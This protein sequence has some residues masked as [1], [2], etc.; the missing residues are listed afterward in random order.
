MSQM[1]RRGTRNGAYLNLPETEL[2]RVLVAGTDRTT[3]ETHLG[4]RLYQRLRDLAIA[5]RKH[6]RS[7]GPC[8]YLLHG[9]MGS[10]LGTRRGALWVNP[11]ALAAGR[12]TELALPGGRGVQ[13]LGLQTFMYLRLRLTLELT[14]F[15][16]RV[17][18]YDWRRDI[19]ALGRELLERVRSESK[20]PVAVVAHSMGGLVARAAMH[21]EQEHKIARLIMLG[22]PSYGSF[23]AV[24]A[25]RGAYPP[26]H[27]I[28]LLDHEHDPDAHAQKV[29]ATFPGLYQLLPEP[30]RL[31]G[32]DLRR[33]TAWPAHGPRLS[34]TLL[35]ESAA[36]RA[37]LAP[38]D[39]RMTLI[40]G[41]Q[42]HTVS[43]MR[44]V[45]GEFLF[46]VTRNGDGTVPLSLA[47][48]RGA[49]TYYVAEGHTELPSN[50]QVIAALVDVLKAGKTSR[51]PRQWRQ[52]RA[53]ARVLRESDLRS[54][55]TISH[56]W[57]ALDAA[58]QRE[59][60][61]GIVFPGRAADD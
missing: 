8:V 46:E 43:A 51:L 6:R 36:Y 24:L 5:A 50:G 44:R 54:T 2:R 38:A 18:A 48:L 52:S 40:A 28:A 26:V 23:A 47:L 16:V 11:A 57:D 35:Q 10:Q 21:R 20:Q 7:R 9:I 39:R 31:G 4:T 41:V 29:F 12:L 14:G 15:D 19:L 34:K 55:Q 42:Q 22:T 17:H 59:L 53:A 33:A 49:R 32:L 58:T 13:A 30:T 45:G 61:E 37:Q 25:L 56:D 1:A 3:L 27:K 60:L